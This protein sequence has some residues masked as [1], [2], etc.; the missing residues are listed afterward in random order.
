M[1][2]TACYFHNFIGS[3]TCNNSE[4]DP[5]GDPPTE[6]GGNSYNRDTV[7]AGGKFGNKQGEFL[8]IAPNLS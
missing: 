3:S 8:G 4:L 2:K 1:S 6:G 5:G 7:I